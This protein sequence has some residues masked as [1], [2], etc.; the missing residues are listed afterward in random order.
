MVALHCQISLS[1]YCF[2]H[3]KI[4]RITVLT[5]SKFACC[6]PGKMEAS[7]SLEMLKFTPCQG[8]RLY[9]KG[10]HETNRQDGDTELF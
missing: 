10:A 2:E 9:L 4:E 6:E 5:K 8:P 7:N 3:Y 1:F